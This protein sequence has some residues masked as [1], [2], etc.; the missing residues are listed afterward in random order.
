MKTLHRS[1][2]PLAILNGLIAK[3]GGVDG[4]VF[5]NIM[6]LISGDMKEEDGW[7]QTLPLVTSLTKRGIA[8]VWLHHT[9]HDETAAM[10]PR[11]ANGG[12]TT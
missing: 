4:I 1:T 8:Q 7:R 11:P 2:L 10:A 3:V 9:G 5:D 6:S 12:W